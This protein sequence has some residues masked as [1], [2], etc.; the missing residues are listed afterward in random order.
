MGLCFALRDMLF[1]HTPE[2]SCR[3][4]LRWSFTQWWAWLDNKDSKNGIIRYN[5]GDRL[6]A[7]ALAAET[8]AVKAALLDAISL[9]LSFKRNFYALRHIVAY[10][11]HIGTFVSRCTLSSCTVS[12][13]PLYKIQLHSLT[14]T[15]LANRSLS[16]L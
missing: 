13:M 16:K 12:D 8:L 5:S 9:E 7:S 15:P 11:L 1:S 2:F 14:L 4:S 10:K 6:I 3:C